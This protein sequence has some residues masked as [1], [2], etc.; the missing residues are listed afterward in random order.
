[1]LKLLKTATLSSNSVVQEDLEMFARDLNSQQVSE[2]MG[3]GVILKNRR[4]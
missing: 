1:M 2:L 4:A 3:R